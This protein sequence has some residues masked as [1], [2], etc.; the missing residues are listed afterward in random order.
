MTSSRGGHWAGG[1][2]TSMIEP[3]DVVVVPEKAVL[4]SGHTWKNIMA[5][6]QIAEAGAIAAAIA[7]P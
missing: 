3:G 7:I 4:G 6:A 2:L 5:V 1:A